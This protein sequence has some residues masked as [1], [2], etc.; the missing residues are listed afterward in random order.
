MKTPQELAQIQINDC[1]QPI[2]PNDGKPPFEYICNHYM[3][4]QRFEE[5]YKYGA[6][7][8]KLIE[9]NETSN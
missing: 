4:M 6:I 3:L 2:E 5:F 1:C 8:I 9:K 7:P